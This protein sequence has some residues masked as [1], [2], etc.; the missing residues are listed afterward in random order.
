MR[1]I[2][3]LMA[4]ALLSSLFI[5]LFYSTQLQMT[6]SH[7][8]LQT[9][10]LRN[11]RLYANDSGAHPSKQDS[12][13]PHLNTADSVAPHLNTANVSVSDSLRKII[14]Q[15]G[16]YWNRLLHSILRQLDKGKYTFRKDRV[17]W[18]Q[19]REINEELLRINVH[20]FN[21]YSMQHQEFVKGMECRHPPILIDQPN[22]CSSSKGEGD[23]Q[24]FLLLA[25]KSRPRNFEQRQAVRETWGREG[26]YQGGLRVRT[27]FLLG[28]SSPDDP[29]LAPLLSFEAKHFG[30]LL[31]WDFHDSLFNLT[32]KEH[33]FYSWS[34]THCPHVSF[35]FK[36][37][38]DVLANTQ[39]ILDYLQS[40]ESS[41]APKIYVGQ[42]ISQAR[43]LR[44]PKSKYYVPLSFYN[45][46]YPAYAGGGGYLF[47]GALLRPLYYISLVIPFFPID[48]VYSGMCF[49][50]LGI[51]P[52][53][54]REF[55]TFDVKKQDRDN[56]CVHKGLLLVHQRSPQQVKRLWKGIHNPF[57]TC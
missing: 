31:Q 19:C 26:V 54:H 23:G 21:S 53:A 15:N 4:M 48:D 13:T 22:K 42:I 41:K 51:S 6:H 52:E 10:F 38:D 2:Q 16:A 55:R 30:D 47:S 57:L 14:P 18:S 17:S 24:T 39:L 7:L 50:A 12:V 43:P 25:I 46:P 27:V 56:T 1:R 44:D 8:S 20:D 34:L 36:G 49:Q 32:L 29:D 11:H 3:A 33:V 40:L 45:G 28:R 5:L 9:D 37:D 35:V